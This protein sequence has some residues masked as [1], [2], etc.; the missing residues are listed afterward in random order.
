MKAGTMHFIHLE[1]R[2]DYSRQR[3]KIQEVSEKNSRPLNLSMS[4]MTPSSRPQIVK[5]TDAI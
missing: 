3:V 4:H 5:S 2:N 1:Q